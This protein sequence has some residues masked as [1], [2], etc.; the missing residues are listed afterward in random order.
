V[1]DCELAI[2]PGT[3]RGL[4]VEKLRFCDR[5]IINILTGDPVPTM[6]PRHRT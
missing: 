1:P 4:L 2:I 6:A 3:S 5:I